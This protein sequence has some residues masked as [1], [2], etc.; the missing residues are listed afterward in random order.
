MK[1]YVDQKNLCAE[2][3]LSKQKVYYTKII[4]DAGNCQ[5]TLLMCVLTKLNKRFYHL[6]LNQRNSR[7]ISIHFTCK[8]Y[9]RFGN[10]YQ[11]IR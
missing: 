3:V 5:K 4:S 9:K 1:R 11:R 6:T 8:K 7:T 2:M 10:L